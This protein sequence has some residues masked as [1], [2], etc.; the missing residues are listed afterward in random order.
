VNDN[1]MG[2]TAWDL[3][4]RR[5]ERVPSGIYLVRVEA[6]DASPVL[7]KAAVIR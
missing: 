3:R 7:K 4:T 2:G 1:R 5:G 6:P